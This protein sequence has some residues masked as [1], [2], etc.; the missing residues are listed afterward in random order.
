MNILMDWGI[1]I[2][3]WLQQ[4]HPALDGVFKVLTF[5]GGEE[6]LML[7]LPFLYWC[8][9]PSLGRRMLL[10]FLFNA[11]TNTASKVWVNQ[12]RPI[13]YDDRV[14]AYSE[15]DGTGG[16]PSGHT[17]NT[18]IIWGFLTSQLR[19]RWLWIVTGVLLILVPL[20]RVY[21]GVHFPHDLLGGY[22]LGGIL[23]FAY[24]TWEAAGG[25]WL[26]SLSPVWQY[27]LVI[28]AALLVALTLPTKNGIAT[29]AIIMG[30][31]IGLLLEMRYVRFT[32][33][34]TWL[35]R[36]MC[37][38]LGLVVLLG[39]WGGLRAAFTDLEPVLLLRF[40]RYSLVGLWLSWGAPWTFVKLG[41]VQGVQK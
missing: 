26:T 36:S 32:V 40:M 15:V 12:P 10:L 5:T 9:D 39:L 17:Q 34:K 6:F 7:L 41:L 18:T 21:L 13:S 22:V 11:Y 8:L 31:G 4:W 25:R 38:V 24:L 33:A 20:S 30:G 3:L 16:F 1:E 37:F 2:I 14:W 23:L 35:R 19:Q 27:S 28:V 29:S